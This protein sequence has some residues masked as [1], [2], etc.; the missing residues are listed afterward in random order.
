MKKIGT[1]PK[2]LIVGDKLLKNFLTTLEYS[3]QNK[4]ATKDNSN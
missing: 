1:R 2:K 3:K 4:F